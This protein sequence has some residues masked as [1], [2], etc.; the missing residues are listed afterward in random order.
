MSAITTHV[1]DT[2]IGQ[3]AAGI[4]VVL[5][6]LAPDG[7]WQQIAAG[8][9]NEDGRV[10]DLLPPNSLV[11]G[12]YRLSFATGEYF[13]HRSQATLYPQ[14][15]IEFQVIDIAEHYHIPLLL[16]PFG[17]STYRGS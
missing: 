10:N 17:Y 12:R 14:V 13:H 15:S 7:R 4:A 11:D 9:T 8:T 1:L 2:S 3:P 5:K 16:S 6:H